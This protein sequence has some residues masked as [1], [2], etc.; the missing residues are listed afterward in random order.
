MFRSGRVLLVLPAAVFLL[1]CAEPAGDTGPMVAELQLTESQASQARPGEP[2]DELPV[3]V[4]SPLIVLDALLQ[5]YPDRVESLAIR[6]GDWSVLIGGEIHYWAEG[7]MLP[8][9]QLEKAEEYSSYSF[10]P[11]PV[12]L[13]PLRELSPEEI[14]R[15]TSR[16]EERETGQDARYQG[17]MTALW[18]ME[19][20][21]TAENTVIRVEFLGRHIRIHPGIRESLVQVETEIL[22]I[23][24]TDV[25]T[26]GWIEGQ[27]DSGAYVWRDIAGS[28]NRSLHSFGIA[29]DLIPGDYRGKQAYWRWADDI[30]DEW[31]T[32]PYEDRY[33]VPEAV[34]EAFEKNGFIW[35][36]KW[37]LFDQIHFEYRPEL[38]IL[39]QLAEG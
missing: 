24:E 25:S 10:R 35:G 27:G 14:E 1:Q 33:M 9:G 22:I 2:I 5:A 12:K 29:L 7:R 18:G 15:L 20:F 19:D 32:I 8:A 4:G 16:L 21:L 6:D 23:A 26:A 28:A 13:P 37:F 39:G 30:Y 38:I 34:V 36:G 17:F 11:N 31:W 3:D